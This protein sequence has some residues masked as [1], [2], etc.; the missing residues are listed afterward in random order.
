M[1]FT[2]QDLL[3][4]TSKPDTDKNFFN[5]TITDLEPNQ[6]YPIQFA[7]IYAD[8]TVGDYSA[9]Y[10]LVT[11]IETAPKRPEFRVE[12]AEGGQNYIRLTWSGKAFDGTSYGNNLD[13]IDVYITN[14]TNVF[15]DG[16]LPAAFFRT[17]GNFLLTAPAGT[18]TITL[19][20]V[21]TRGRISAASDARTVTVTGEAAVEPPT[22][23]A[24]L[25]ATTAPFGLTVNWNGT[26]AGAAFAGFKA[27]RIFASAIDRGAS[28]TTGISNSNVV[29]NLTIDQTT[30]KLNIGL[31]NLRTALGLASNAAVYNDN[32]QGVPQPWIYLYYVTTNTLNQDYSVGGVITYTRIN[33]TALVPTK[34][35]FID[36]ERG[37]ISIENLIAGNG[38][39]TSWLRTGSAGGGR[40]EL[41]GVTS[42][43]IPSGESLNVLPGLAVYSTGS[44][45]IFRADLAG[46]VAFGDYTPDDIEQIEG[47]ATTAS[48][49]ATTANTNALSA[50]SGL[51]TKLATTGSI[52]ADPI[53]K[54]LTAINANGVT[55][56]ATPNSTGTVPTQGARIVMNSLGIVAF[57]SSSTDNLTGITFSLSASNGNAL[58]RGSIEASTIT[59][60]TILTS[61][62][63]P[64]IRLQDGGSNRDRIFFEYNST[65]SYNINSD[66]TG[67][68]IIGPGQ[69]RISL[70]TSEIIMVNPVKNFSATALGDMAYRAMT[71]VP[72]TSAPA[73][74]STVTTAHASGAIIL[75]YQS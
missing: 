31:D 15:G 44:T 33:S 37:V 21:T 73:H 2:P 41:S 42:S 25:S 46:N 14:S 7:W 12:D 36:L 5:I 4:D 68:N 48:T 69:S 45:P 62:S 54:Q 22:L 30:N 65:T 47:I 61:T 29:G 3:K 74:N 26:Y 50:L 57:N 8:K 10:P 56:Y 38:Q 59:G 35:N 40:I 16:S 27:V 72:S 51:E 28:T 53:T 60:G 13:R 6:T 66:A 9:T 49:T 20:A 32:A 64:R 67:L 39:F 24:G 34:A 63:Y 71:A 43:F 18:Y 52:I 58:F 70:G 55:V 1:S 75:A 19:K 23:A 17:P 11:D